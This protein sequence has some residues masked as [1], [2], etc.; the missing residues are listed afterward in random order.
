MRSRIIGYRFHVLVD[1][2]RKRAVS[3]EDRIPRALKSQTGGHPTAQPACPSGPR[4]I[5]FPDPQR[6]T[7]ALGME[8]I[9]QCPRQAKARFSGLQTARDGGFG[10]AVRYRSPATDLTSSLVSAPGKNCPAN[11]PTGREKRVFGTF[12][13]PN[14]AKTRGFVTVEAPGSE[15]RF[16]WGTHSPYPVSRFSGPRRRSGGPAA[17][18]WCRG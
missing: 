16:L 11:C 3:I 1:R 10:G 7:G 2:Q 12:L 4:R 17:G 6:L 8:G 14:C 15:F 18:R 9:A 13:D 5:P